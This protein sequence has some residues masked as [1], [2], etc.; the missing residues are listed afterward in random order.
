[1]NLVK[2]ETFF[3]DSTHKKANENK[4][5]Y[6]SEIVKEVKKRR[7]WLEEEINN[8][9]KKQNKKEFSYEDEVETKEI[10]VSNTDAENR[11]NKEKGFMYLDHR[12]VDS[13]CNIIVDCHIIK[14]NVHD[15]VPYISRLEYIKINLDL[16]LKKS[17]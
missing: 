17:E 11:D 1:M 10:K 5:K 2:G 14:G 13:K 4:N 12:T 15:S 7:I 3:T 16:I 6:H 9:H 8:E